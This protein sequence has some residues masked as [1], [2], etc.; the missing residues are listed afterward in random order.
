MLTA[1]TDAEGEVGR[2]GR[3]GCSTP[4]KILPC[5]SS[6]LKRILIIDAFMEKQRSVDVRQVVQHFLSWKAI[7]T[8][9]VDVHCSMACPRYTVTWPL[10][11]CRIF[12]LMWQ[13][14][15]SQFNI[16]SASKKSH[17]HSL[18]ASLK[19]HFFSVEV[20]FTPVPSLSIN[21]H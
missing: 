17:I 10:F 11:F 14:M 19:S 7:I 4:P 18:S 8:V 2:G 21:Y 12:Y 16:S 13:N 6:T 3:S 5:I 15:K 9:T 20:D 1:I